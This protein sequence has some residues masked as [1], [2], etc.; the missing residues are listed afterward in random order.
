[1]AYQPY[2]SYTSESESESESDGYGSESD[3]FE[4]VKQDPR[5]EI[6]RMPS[7]ASNIKNDLSKAPGA[8]WDDSKNVS[9]LENYEYIAPPRSTKT[10]LF[11]MKSI[12]RDKNVYPTPYNFQLKLPR[13]YKNVTKFQL[14]QLSF[15]NNSNGVTASN[16][17]ISS[18]VQDMLNNGI[19]ADCIDTCISIT[20]C[21]PA[22]NTV[23]MYEFGR[24]NGV[25]QSL[26]TTVSVPDGFY[27]NSQ[28]ADELTFQSSSTPPLNIISYPQFRDTFV[29]TRDIYVLFNEPGDNFYSKTGRR[30]N[31]PTKEA[32]MNT[33][34]TQQHINGLNEITEQVAFTAYYYP[35][36]KELLATG[37]AEPFLQNYAE[38]HERVLGIFEGLD[39]QFYYSVC[40]EYQGAL[41][42]FRKHL[43]FELRPINSYSWKYNDNEK[44]FTTIHNQIHA[45]IQRDIS[46]QY[47]TVTNRELALASLNP[48]SFT[49]LKNN[50]VAYSAIYKHLE[51]NLSTVLGRY[52]LV[53][54]YTYGGGELH[55]TQESTFNMTDLHADSDFTTMFEYRSSIGGIY[56][57]YEG[58]IMNFRN[59]LDYHSTLSTYYTIVQNTNN[60]INC[61]NKSIAMNHHM[62]VST[63]YTNVLPQR[64]IDTRAYTSNQSLPVSF[65][66]SA[67][68]YV[69]GMAAI[70]APNAPNTSEPIA[71]E[72]IAV[73]ILNAPDPNAPNPNAPNPNAPNPSGLT[74]LSDLIDLTSATDRLTN[75]MAASTPSSVC[76]TLCCTYINKMLTKWYSTLPVNSVIG[77]LTYRLGLVN[78]APNQYNIVS[79]I[80]SYNTSGALNFLMQINDEQGFNNMD[81]AMNENYS[82]GNDTTGQ[83]KLV[84]AKILMGNVGDSGVSQTLI[85]NPSIFENTLGKLDRLNIK[86]YYDDPAL[87]PAWLYLPFQYDVNEWNATFQIDEEVGFINQADNW[88]LVPSIPI[89]KNPN[90]LPYIYLSKVEKK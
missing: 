2:A 71:P 32:I 76:S 75:I 62:Y 66:T 52:A 89:P 16:L 65:V 18:L 21:T 23:G 81:I 54:N 61:I 40:Q 13:I 41:D 60:T 46:K 70:G 68:A 42:T 26:L 83:I 14:V 38:I 64:I 27:T 80:L 86:I 50:S 77:T 56:G 43:T 72:P 48:G 74:D 82:I 5:Y 90:E 33:Y 44:R 69:P 88:P 79:T 11:S 3:G 28:L 53:S 30:I 10:S 84:A 17:F 37:M 6:L 1:M 34:Y 67:Q 55:I 9:S 49:T 15:P 8:P 63:K 51:T 78:I 35:V 12:N 25:G 58:T 59:F 73:T 24:V 39:S 19:P 47:Q 20:T 22:A 57:N 87:T 85:Q 4:D 45:S 31:K 36:L 29:N 7:S